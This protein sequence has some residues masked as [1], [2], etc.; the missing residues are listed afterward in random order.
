MMAARQPKY[1]R[2][3]LNLSAAVCTYAENY[4]TQLRKDIVAACRS[5][6]RDAA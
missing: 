4:E 5:T 2:A 3:G 6:C 1:R